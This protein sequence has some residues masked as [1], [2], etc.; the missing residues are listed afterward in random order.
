MTRLL[1]SPSGP[2]MG[3]AEAWPWAPGVG[4]A[5]LCTAGITDERSRYLVWGLPA[6][7]VLRADPWPY[8][9]SEPATKRSDPL[10]NLRGP[11]RVQDDRPT[12]LTRVQIALPRH[13]PGDSGSSLG[14]SVA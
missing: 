14:T 9:G 13:R 11:T 6:A 5:V 12:K 10:S 7:R 2:V 1:R 8:P 4:T 3:W